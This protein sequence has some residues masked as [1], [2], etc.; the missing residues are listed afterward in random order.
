MCFEVMM[1]VTDLVMKFA[2]IGVFALVAKVV[3]ISGFE[4]FKPLLV[5][6]FTVLIALLIHIA[7]VMP[8]LLRFIGGV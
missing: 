3:T 6:F 5:F 1:L 4:A 7:V 2:P 8:L